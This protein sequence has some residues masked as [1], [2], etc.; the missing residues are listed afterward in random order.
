MKSRL[1]F[2]HAIS[3]LHAGTGQG[4]GVMDL[5]VAREKAT[6]LPYLPGSSLKG[7]LRDACEDKEM[8]TAVFGPDP[9][10]DVAHAGSAAFSDLRL[11]LL[12][13]RSVLGT[14]AWVTSPYVLRRFLRDADSAG[15][16]DVPS[17]VPDVVEGHCFVSDAGSVIAE[18]SKVLLEDLNLVSETSGNAR[19]W[20]E[21][22]GRQVFP[23]DSVWQ[24]MLVQRL[25]IVSDDV[26]SFLLDTATEV[27]SRIRLQEDTKTVAKG[28]L[29]Y[30][31]ALPAETVLSGIVAASPV[32]AAPEQVFATLGRLV[33]KPL[34][35]G[36][37]ATVGR[38]LCRVTLGG[39]DQQ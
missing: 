16:T 15:V 3:P 5:P 11:L 33:Q 36:G 35:L 22:M 18:A 12:P 7:V 8:R 24:T 25:C 37:K 9:A 38:G 13:V 2:V 20:A 21:W 32:K 30:E 27:F 6:G 1:V 14:F 31:E 34:Q 26:L 23:D 4:V 29:W 10:S 39:G 19:R 17:E 28:G